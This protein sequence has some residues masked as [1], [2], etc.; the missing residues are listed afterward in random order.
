[1]PSKGPYSAG[2]AF[3]TVVPSFL[4]VEKA[5]KE[6]VRQMARAADKDLAAGMARGL[7]DVQKQAKDVGGKSGQ[8]FAG[9][10]EAEAKKKLTQAWKNLPEP[11]PDVNLRKWDKAL[12]RVRSEM[13]ELAGQRIGIDLDQP[14][15]E[16][17]VDDFRRKLEALRDSASG[18]NR[19]V[20]FFNADQAAKSLADLQKFTDEAS[21]RAGVGGE[22]A[23]SAFVQRMSR[24]LREGIDKLPP[25]TLTADSTQAERQIAGLRERMVDLQD[26]RIGVDIDAGA[27]YAELRAIQG[28]LQR[29][30]RTN[31]RVDIRTNAHEAATGMG[32]FVQQAELAGQATGNIGERSNFS[33]SRLEYLIALGASLGTAIVPAAMAAVGAIGLIGTTAIAAGAGIGVFALGVSG[34]SDAVKALN[35]NAQDQQK[36][37]S[38]ISQANDRVAS[39]TDQVR[40]S[41]MALANTRRNVAEAA[42]DA[43]RR[44]VDAERGVGDARRAA[45]QE[46]ADAA[47]TV[48]D[49]RRDAADAEDN[50]ADARR[51]ARLDLV[52]ADRQV[53]DAQRG[54]TDAEQDARDARL[55]LNEA[56]QQAVLDMRELDT[57]LA[58]N[59]QEQSKAT[60]AQMKALEELNRLKMNPRATEVELRQAQDSYNEQTVRLKELQ[61]QQRRLAQEKKR[62]DDLGVEGDKNVIAARKRIREQDQQLG[63]ARERLDREQQQRV[64]I[65]IRAQER[66]SDAQ[67]RVSR[68]HEQ[69]SRA[70]QQQAQAEIKAQQRIADAQRQ[71]ADAR[72]AQARQAQDGEYQLAQA[73]NAVTQAQRSQRQAWD[74][75]GVAGGAALEKLNESMAG[76]TPKAQHFAKFLFGLKDEVLGLRAAASDPLLPALEDAINLL[77][78]YLPAVEKFVGK[79]ATVMGELAVKSVKALGDPVWQRFFGYIDKTAAPALQT[80]YEIGQNTAQGLISL[81]LAL[82]PFNDQVGTGLVELS[83]DFALWAE[84]LDRSQGYQDFLDY[85]RENGPRVVH[86]L[87]EVGEL[88]IDLVKAAAPLGAIVLQ[89]LTLLVEVLNSIPQGALTL[90]VLGI[91]AVS[92]GL[93][94]LGGIMRVLKL[95]EQLTDIFGPRASRMLQTYAI[96][97]GRATNETGRF[98]KVTATI[99]G[100]AQAAR[101]RVAE[102]GTTLGALRD[103]VIGARAETAPLATGL[104]AVGTAA[105][106]TTKAVAGPSGLLGALQTGHERMN[107]FGTSA[108]AAATGGLAKVRGAVF[109]VAAAVGGPGGIAAGAQTAGTKI[110][111]MGRA[112]GG[113]ATAIGTKL[114]TGLSSATAF[115]GG[116]WGIALGV[117]TIAVTYFATKSAEQKQKVETLTAALTALG[118]EYRDLAVD[119]KQ[120]GEEADKAFRAIV[121]NNPD[122]QRAVIS[123][124]RLGI[125]FDEMVR[126]S[127]SGDPS[128]L[129]RKLNAEID[130]QNE[131]SK[132]WEQTQRILADAAEK[133][134]YHQ[135]AKDLEAV[136]DAFEKN[137]KTMG[138]ATQAQ[139]ILNA[140]SERARVVEQ[141]KLLGTREGLAAQQD[142]IGAYDRNATQIDA[143]SRVVSVF[144]S[145]ESTAS[146][147]ADAMRAAIDAQTG[148]VTSAIEQDELFTSKLISL[149]EQV[150][151]AKASHDKHATSLNLNSATALRNRDALEDVATATRD[152]YLQDIAAGKPM[153][154][155]IKK[156]ND[157]ITAL[158]KEAEKLGLTKTETNKLIDAYGGIP[159][160]VSTL[161]KTDGFTK[162]YNELAQLKFI[163]ESLAKGW[164]LERARNEWSKLR[165]TS[166]TPGATMGP[167]KKAE[168]GPI[169]GPGTKTSDSVLLWGSDGEFMQQAAAVDYYGDAFMA[170]INEKR[171]PKDMLPGFAGGG[172]VTAPTIWPFKVDATKTFVPD[173][174][175][176]ADNFAGALGSAGGGQGYK[177]QMAVL[178]KVFPGLELISGPRPGSRTLSGNLSWH[179]RGRA[180]DVP[181]RRKVA[182][183]IATTYGKNTLELIT[184]WRDLMLYKG[185]PHK[186]S[187]AVEAQHGVGSAGNDHIHWAF[188][189]G[190]M[191]PPGEST[192]FNGTGRPEPVLT[193]QQWNT[194]MAAARGGDG[195]SGNTYQFEFRDT[196]LDPS[197]LRALQDR[198]AVMA[199]HGRA[200]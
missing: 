6:Q 160:N 135:Q 164:T 153:T 139:D 83:R 169:V 78:P 16:K 123:L 47:R 157:R 101:T 31:V 105:G 80:L 95:R 29:L 162:V 35:A 25:I 68:A 82:T 39:S 185:H 10:Y 86:F 36:S 154:D 141:A 79:I 178:R 4:G 182:E 120:A 136:R 167:P 119:G 200:R 131:L 12:A 125:S 187:A 66:I 27:A 151:Q 19:E 13:K 156:H 126:A 104:G 53:R 64:Q 186:F 163:Q 56:I 41:Q 190:G 189:Q 97:T 184:P 168:G 20:N 142:L 59:G 14:T 9:A 2:T 91:G 26:K 115:L 183:W 175:T 102:Y 93:T 3:L 49:A 193:D 85:V 42:Q 132:E 112:A 148:S 92:L 34:I 28:E 15:F 122:L 88:L 89:G 138:V 118:N 38:S 155:V 71:V 191:L 74:K 1:M 179:S 172:K 30:D 54:V 43:A 144:S 195:A 60:T 188:D 75:T 69:V 196:T 94:A 73:S 146:Q 50:L 128:E 124:D 177:W 198:E 55:A 98:G 90:L 121:E 48:R 127:T 77:L 134:P 33:L 8:D 70:Q 137:A 37:A 22:Q 133:N 52:E 44:V 171:I 166:L 67:E 5:F 158:R 161:I 23:G 180:V 81:F 96:D 117:A 109:D 181:A 108:N 194:I 24:V 113:A 32:Q 99:G 51:Q 62:A 87:G 111:G 159:P 46:L 140:S 170:A 106:N 114:M 116:P 45:Q 174:S 173:E 165:E 150:N 107:A 40:M 147:K 76:L 110:A 149:R 17:A 7:K 145:A 21:R 11:Q 192:V 84:R 152:M 197:K 103:R 130:R 18:Q 100:V 65:Q 199:R 176:I 58:R 129:V 143:L 61:D 57:Q 63:K 72:R